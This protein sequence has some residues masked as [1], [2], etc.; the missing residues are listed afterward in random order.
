MKYPK[1]L[2]EGAQPGVPMVLIVPIDFF[3]KSTKKIRENVNSN[4]L[5]GDGRLFSYPTVINFLDVTCTLR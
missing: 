2:A 3:Q 4:V 1:S 5:V